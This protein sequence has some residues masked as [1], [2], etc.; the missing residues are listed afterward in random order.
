MMITMTE[1]P[2]TPL[3]G[4]SLAQLTWLTGQWT[5]QRGADTVEETWSGPAGGTMIGMFRWIRAGVP[6]LY[7]LTALEPVED[8]ILFR[9]KHFHPG[10]VGWEEKDRCVTFV[11]VAVDEDGAVFHQRDVDDPP[12]MI[13]QRRADGGLDSWF[14]RPGR[15]VADSDVFRYHA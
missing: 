15:E 1:Y 14:R 11:L 10:L 7:E 13:Y 2:T 12:W 6:Y 9:I 5:G 4:A 8:T 3:R